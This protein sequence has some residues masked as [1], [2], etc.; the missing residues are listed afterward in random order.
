MTPPRRPGPD[1]TLDS[2]RAQLIDAGIVLLRRRGVE[3]GLGEITLSDAIA[4][5]GVT[6][7]TAYRSLAD[8]TLA[9]QAM[10]H[11]ELIT[12]LLTRYSRGDTRDA[13]EG[14][15]AQDLA[16]HEQALESG[17]TQQRTL[18]MRSII[19]VGANTSYEGVIDSPERAILTAMYGA[20]RSS[21]E[22]PDWRHEALTEGEQNLNAM[23]S[24]L[25]RG[26]AELFHY[27]VKPPFTMDQ[28]TAAGASL[29]EG[30]AMRHE[31]NPEL[32]TTQRPTGPAG[33][34]ESWTLFAIAFEAM[35]VGM[36]EPD[37]PD[38]PFADLLRY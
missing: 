6:R 19:R 38:A 22:P 20:V 15:I 21:T 30:L 10:L 26:L 2:V 1:S 9:P 4:E 3:L 25:Y 17:T 11:R 31:F 27:R 35:F 37:N 23:F 12:Y 24:A 33:Q 8:E 16:R 34:D 32:A 13:I 36:C 18:A 28:F 14:A 7:S 29:I 5:A